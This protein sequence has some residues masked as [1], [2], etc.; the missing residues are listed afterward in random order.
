MVTVKINTQTEILLSYSTHPVRKLNQRVN[1][2]KELP[3]NEF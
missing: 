2:V 3:V 1:F